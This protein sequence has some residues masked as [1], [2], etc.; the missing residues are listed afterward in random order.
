METMAVA[1]MRN[2]NLL[3]CSGIVEFAQK[4]RMAID[5]WKEAHL[6]LAVGKKVTACETH[7]SCDA[8]KMQS[9]F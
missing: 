1:R 9:W 5:W 3:S 6:A 4:I 7:R 2:N 8:S